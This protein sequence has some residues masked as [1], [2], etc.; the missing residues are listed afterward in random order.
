MWWIRYSLYSMCCTA[1]IIIATILLVMFLHWWAIIMKS[2]VEM[3]SF[4]LS[5]LTVK[6][7]SPLLS[8]IENLSTSIFEKN[9]LFVALH[10]KDV[11]TLDSYVETDEKNWSCTSALKKV[12]MLE[13]NRY[14]WKL[15]SNITLKIE[16]IIRFK[17][18]CKKR[19]Y[20]KKEQCG[21]ITA[22]HPPHRN[23]GNHWIIAVT[24]L[25]MWNRCNNFKRIIEVWK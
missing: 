15:V 9:W 18:Q 1:A 17:C 2:H 12:S 22:I 7:R 21:S 10:S 25:N 13:R 16:R 8:L 3:G 4:T 14:Y 19:C 23:W 11:K 6:K 24:Y 20:N 5:S